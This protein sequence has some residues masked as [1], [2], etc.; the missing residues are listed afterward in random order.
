MRPDK[1]TLAEEE[2]HL[3]EGMMTLFYRDG[4]YRH[5]FFGGFALVQI[6]AEEFDPNVVENPT[7][8]AMMILEDRAV[9]VIKD[10][11]I[12]PFRAAL[13]TMR[14]EEGE[15]EQEGFEVYWRGSLIHQEFNEEYEPVERTEE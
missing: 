6:L 10:H 7:E 11:L 8:E 4:D 1:P 13:Q 12:P 5:Q 14:S 15:P 9:D 3:S 2:R